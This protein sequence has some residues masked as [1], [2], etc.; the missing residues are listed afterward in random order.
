[1][2]LCEL[3]KLFNPGIKESEITECMNY[4][5][6]HHCTLVSVAKMDDIDLEIVIDCCYDY[7]PKYCLGAILGDT[8]I[9]DDY[10][11]DDDITFDQ[12]IDFKTEIKKYCYYL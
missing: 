5:N 10:Y 8:W 6:E 3:L 2:I 1:M 7:C 9:I 11:F 4:A 12:F